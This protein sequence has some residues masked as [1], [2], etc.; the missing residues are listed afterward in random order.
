[1]TNPWFTRSLFVT[2]SRHRLGDAWL[3][4]NEQWVN[5]QDNIN[6]AQMIGSLTSTWILQG[7]QGH[8]YSC[9]YIKHMSL[10]W[11]RQLTKNFDDHLQNIFLTHTE[12]AGIYGVYWGSSLAQ[13]VAWLALLFYLMNSTSLNSLHGNIKHNWIFNTIKL[14]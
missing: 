6:A 4:N 12:P 5:T 11:G 8:S 14:I 7:K 9:P 10:N 3:S 13:F 1:M 2:L